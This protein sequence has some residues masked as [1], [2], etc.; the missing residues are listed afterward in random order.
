MRTFIAVEFDPVIKRNLS[1]FL[2]R[3]KKLGP[4]N[5]SWVREEGMHLTLKFL[6]EIEES[7]SSTIR[8]IIS[9]VSKK[10]LRFPLTVKGAGF[11]PANPKYIRVLWVGVEDQPI[12]IGLQKELESELEKLG[13]AREKR[14]FHPHLTL[15]R[16]RAP[17]NLK[18]ILEELEKNKTAVFGEMTVQRITFFQS[19]LKPS[20]AEYTALAECELS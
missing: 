7:Q 1:D 10:R 9:A 18:E 8:D 13:F 5:I 12:L 20:G 19:R 16:V 4:K 2:G 14:T 3:L 17:S 11:F 6:G 15:G